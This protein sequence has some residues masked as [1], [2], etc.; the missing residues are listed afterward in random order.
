MWTWRISPSFSPGSADSSPIRLDIRGD[1]DAGRFGLRRSVG[2][3]I[4]GAEDEKSASVKVSVDGFAHGHGAE[5]LQALGEGL[6]E[7]FGHV[8]DDG[9]GRKVSGNLGQ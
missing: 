9:N 8:L 7:R 6:G 4:S 3:S 1:G 5:P 2:V